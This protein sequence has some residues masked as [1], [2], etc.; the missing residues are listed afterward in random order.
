MMSALEL[1]HQWDVGHAVRALEEASSR[2]VDDEDFCRIA[3]VA[4]RLQLPMLMSACM[5][6]AKNSND[7]K[8]RFKTSHY[9]PAIQTM[10][11]KVFGD[12]DSGDSRRKRRRIVTCAFST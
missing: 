8:K 7:V 11:G 1:A 9:P 5:A 6:H 2:T 4:T 12:T 3:E 10:L